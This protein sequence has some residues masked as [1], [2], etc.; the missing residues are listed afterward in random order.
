MLGFVGDVQSLV[1]ALRSYRD[2]DASGIGMILGTDEGTG[3]SVGF[4][5]RPRSDFLV[6]CAVESSAQNLHELR[7]EVNRMRAGLAD[8]Y[9][10]RLGSDCTTQ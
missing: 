4:V 10:E 8:L 9:A 6:G 2:G 5:H 7:Q 3:S 1:R